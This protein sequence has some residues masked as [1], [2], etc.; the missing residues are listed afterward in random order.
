[1]R[2]KKKTEAN[3]IIKAMRHYLGMTQEQVAK[4][5]EI[6]LCV[7]QKY[8]NVPGELLRGSFSD[9]YRILEI[10]QLEPKDLLDGKYKLNAL[11]RQITS[12]G[13]GPLN[14]ILRKSL[15]NCC[16]VISKE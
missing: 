14:N 8:E 4:K 10:L 1:M 5:C 16:P 11:G 7:Y 3:K 9:V 15:Q 6:S 13:T 2:P 12:R